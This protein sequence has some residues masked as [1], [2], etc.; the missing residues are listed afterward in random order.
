MKITLISPRLAIQKG[1]F[2]GSGVLYWPLELAVLA[3]FLRQEG[4]SVEVIDLLGMAPFTL[5][6]R[7]DHYLQGK[8]FHDCR[9]SSEVLQSEVFIIYALSY[10]SHQEVLSIA[11]EIRHI[12]DDAHI[13]IL[14]NAQAVTAYSLDT[15]S[16]EMFRSG[17]DL[18]LCGEVYWNW[19]DIRSYLEHPDSIPVPGNVLTLETSPGRVVQ[20]IINQHPSYPVPAWDL[21]PLSSYW[22]LPYSHGPKTAKYLPL[23]TSRGC[24]FPC[25]FCVSPA[26]NQSKWRGRSPDEIVSEM[27]ALRDKF[28]VRHFQVEDLNPT[29]DSARWLEICRE[30]IAKNAGIF[31]YFVSGTKAETIRVEDIPLYA[32]AGCRYLSISPESGN[33]E[34]LKIIGKS[35]DYEH[36]IKLVRACHQHGIY[37]QACLLVG[38]PAEAGNQGWQLS[39]DYIRRLVNAGLDEVGIFIV[40]ALP[41]S[42]LAL[43]GK[44]DFVSRQALVSFSPKGRSGWEK[45]DYQRRQLIRIFLWEKLKQGTAI[46]IQGIRALLGIPRTKMENLPRRI[47][48]MYGLLLKNYLQK[49]IRKGNL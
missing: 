3:A 32:Q 29:V 11:G 10:M 45:L 30:L 33:P 21:F 26:M 43:E 17:V 20:R 7:G 42:R 8:A 16:E 15:V 22:S 40:A 39:G 2:F 28:G 44:V 19:R 14:E 49:I 18:L 1:D 46:W 25:D 37:T 27:I 9:L 12:K 6:D 41:G 38:H 36:G 34:V 31:Y 48:W 24:P 13:A 4:D 23:L 35:F 47:I 5:E